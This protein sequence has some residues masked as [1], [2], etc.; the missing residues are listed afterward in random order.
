[1]DNPIRQR[2]QVKEVIKRQIVKSTSRAI[3]VERQI[4]KGRSRDMKYFPKYDVCEHRFECAG[5]PADPHVHHLVFTKAPAHRGQ[6]K[7]EEVGDQNNYANRVK[8]AASLWPFFFRAFHTT[9]SLRGDHT[10]IPE[11]LPLRLPRLYNLLR[12]VVCGGRDQD[13]FYK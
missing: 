4:V 7:V 8:Q 1:L 10:I 12:R 2:I 5:L 11:L 3:Q 9:R 13:S 6:R